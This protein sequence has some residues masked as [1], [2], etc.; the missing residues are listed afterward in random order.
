MGENEQSSEQHAMNWIEIIELRATGRHP[1]RLDAQ[2]REFHRQV[3]KNEEK[4]A[5][6]FYTR[7]GIDTDVS[8]HL[9]HASSEVSRRGSPL[10]QRLVSA[11]K[12]YG[13]V[14]NTIWIENG[15]VR[16]GQG[17]GGTKP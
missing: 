3:E 7:P 11:L 5:V 1:S 8:I 13:L 16:E 10:G 2:L 9:F 17:S 6:K 15:M 4:Q 14:N 12:P